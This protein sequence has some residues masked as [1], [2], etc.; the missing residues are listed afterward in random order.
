MAI[1][2][3]LVLLG[4]QNLVLGHHKAIYDRNGMLAPWTSWTDAL[5]RE[6][7]WYEKCPTDHGY[8]LFTTVTFMDSHFSVAGQRT[9]SIPAMQNGVGI[10]SYLAYDDFTHHKDPSCVATARKMGDYILDQALTPDEGVYPRFPRSTGR[11]GEWPQKPDCGSQDDQPYEIQPDKGAIAGYALL[12]LYEATHEDRYLQEALA[13]ARVLVKTQRAGDAT[14]SPWPFRADFRTGAPRNEVCGDTGFYLRLFD[15]LKKLGY[16]EFDGARAATWSW[17]K[18]FQIPSAAGDGWLFVQFFEDHH[19]E[20]NRTAWGPLN[21]ARYLIEAKA[22]VD[23]EWQADAKTLIDFVNRT[24][25]HVR[26]GVTICGEQDEDHDPW[27][28]I[29]STWGAVL[30]MYSKATNSV[31]YRNLARQTLTFCLYAVADDGCPRDSLHNPEDGGW[32]E[33]AH[34]DKVHNIVDALNAFPEWGK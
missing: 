24:F 7:K 1:L 9:D 4:A 30:A 28:G 19:N 29:N 25:T 22:A 23:P 13:I 21:L 10:L 31:E 34:T 18:N 8:P 5:D 6:M 2:P 3:L 32:Q 33:D 11:A 27:G 17:I 12:S 16:N 26:F 15:G 20:N 14:H